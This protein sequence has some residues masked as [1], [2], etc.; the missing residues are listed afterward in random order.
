MFGLG[1]AV[2]TGIG[3]SINIVP[4]GLDLRGLCLSLPGWLSSCKQAFFHSWSLRAPPE[5]WISIKALE[6]G[7]LLSQAVG[8]GSEA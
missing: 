1:D 3:P 5:K 2:I 4:E 6:E 8:L 7:S